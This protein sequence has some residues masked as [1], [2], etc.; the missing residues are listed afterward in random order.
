MNYHRNIQLPINNGKNIKNQDFD[1]GEMIMSLYINDKYQIVP[2]DYGTFVLFANDTN[3]FLIGKIK[4]DSYN[5]R[6]NASLKSVSL[7]IESK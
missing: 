3:I 4:Q 2:T 5:Y 6:A 1:H 7:Y